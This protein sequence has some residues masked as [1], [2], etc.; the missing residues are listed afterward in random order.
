MN[1]KDVLNEYNTATMELLRL[2]SSLTEKQLNKKTKERGWTVAQVGEHLKK[3][4]EVSG[5][6]NGKVKDIQ[7]SPYEKL[8]EIQR[9][10]LNFDIKMNSPK[11]IIP[12]EEF[13]N[14]E[15]LLTELKNKIQWVNDF[16]KKT[17]LSKLCLDFEIPEY[18]PFTRIEWIGFNTAHTQRH[19]YQVKQII[20]NIKL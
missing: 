12:T 18:G 10:F 13:I 20:R 8:S 15:I 4:Y 7:R 5:V 1:D 3:S 9:L 19:I 11:E 16:S 6:L 17:D 14:K 2:I